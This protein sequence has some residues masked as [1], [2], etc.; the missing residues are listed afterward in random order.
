M[1]P[2]NHKVL[3]KQKKKF[4]FIFFITLLVVFWSSYFTI[5][6]AKK[7]VEVLEKKYAT[8]NKIFEEQAA[9]TFDVDEIIKKLHQFK[10][11]KRTLSEHKQFQLLISDLR[12]QVKKVIHK[13]ESK[14][15]AFI[16]YKELLEEIKT[17]Q[18]VVD[19][20][21]IVEDEYQE[22]KE[23]YERCI[24]RYSELNTKK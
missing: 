3:N 5:T 9:I 13:S 2:L 19:Q 21:R 20:F 11:G 1:K 4:L 22:D 6:T 10:S 16:L 12:V 14:S 7:G 24:E 8:Y 17:I 23:L 15:E 18:S